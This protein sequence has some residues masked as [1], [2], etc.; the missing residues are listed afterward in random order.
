MFIKGHKINV[1]KQNL[2]GFRHSEETKRKM[3]ETHK[4]IG[5]KPPSFL[6]KKH[7]EEYKKVMSLK[8]KG[9]KC[10][11]NIIRN[12]D[13]KFWTPELR[14]KMSKIKKGQ[15]ISL[16]S[17]EKTRQKNIGK[18]RTPEQRM[19]MSLKH[20]GD[21]TNFWKGGITLINEVI[22]NGVEFRLWREAVF[23]RDNHTCQRCMVR[24][25][26]L[27]PHHIL[28]FSS[29]VELRFAIDNGV[30]LCKKCHD[31]FHKIYGHKDNTRE[32]LI[33]YLKTNE[34]TRP[35]QETK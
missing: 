4:R 21:K 1:G 13:P 27:H 2:L 12:K 20:R 9:R 16:E 15:V 24:G 23:V 33:E 17:I 22:R 32:Q 26:H 19:K 6:G 7:T 14:S 8:M 30:T 29:Y 31:Y 3:S 25:G 11:W 10:P 34:T 28:N 35:T 18:K 5:N